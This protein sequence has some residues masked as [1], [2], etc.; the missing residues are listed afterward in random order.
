MLTTYTKLNRSASIFLGGNS[1]SSQEKSRPQTQGAPNAGGAVS[2]ASSEPSLP[3]RREA[4][5][6]QLESRGLDERPGRLSIMINGEE[7]VDMWS[8]QAHG[9]GILC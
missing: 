9:I 5:D 2:A 8:E 1:K 7:F 6:E 3:R 4:I